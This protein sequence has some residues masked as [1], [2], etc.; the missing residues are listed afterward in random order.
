M[1]RFAFR[2]A[3][4]LAV[5]GLATLATL[6]PATQA[7][8]DQSA[9]P[10]P[11]SMAAIG[12]SWTMPYCTDSDCTVKPRD[13]WSTGWN[14]AVD[15]QY[16]RILTANKAIQGR[17][18]NIADQADTP[19]SGVADLSFQAG[20][21][22]AKKVDY[23]TIA[24]GENDICAATPASFRA[25]FKAGMDKLTKGLPRAN[26]FVASIDDLTHQW[27]ALHADP[28]I[29]T[30]VY[31]DCGLGPSTTP[32]QLHTL[33]NQIITLNKQLS[34]VCR[35]YPHCRYDNGA[36]FRIAW[37]EK[38]FSPLDYGHLSIAGQHLLAA[39]TWKAT[40]PFSK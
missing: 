31:L 13:S 18:Y 39:A 21:A 9:V 19:G 38:D 12:D 6:V 23:V 8:Q 4:L 35:H 20:K 33:R 24:L 16:L 14:P 36:V 17:N 40:F 7:A 26:I 2:P 30:T 25:N 29:R 27:Q 1:S 10:Y 28:A 11:D 22:I 3:Q 15:S 34:T 32:N 5:A 37:Q